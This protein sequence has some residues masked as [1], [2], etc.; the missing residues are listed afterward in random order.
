[1]AAATSLP[2]IWVW[3]LAPDKMVFS[4]VT[5]SQPTPKTNVR[6]RSTDPMRWTALVVVRL[7]LAAVAASFHLR[8]RNRGLMSG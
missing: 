3:V 1:M 8:E 5:G 7:L 6:H 2:P 4:Q